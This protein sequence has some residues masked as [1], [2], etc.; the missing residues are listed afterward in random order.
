[1]KQIIVKSRKTLIEEVP[2]VLSDGNVLV[3]VAY[4][5]ISQRT[6]I[7]G[8]RTSGKNKIGKILV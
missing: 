1:M 5:C 7:S 8:I 4:L 3:K 6:E 2:K